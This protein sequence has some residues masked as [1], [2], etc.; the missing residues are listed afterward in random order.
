[1][2]CNLCAVLTLLVALAKPY[3]SPKLISDSSEPSR[4]G[5]ENILV[6]RQVFPVMRFGWS[7][8]TLR[9]LSLLPSRRGRE[10]IKVLFSGLSCDTLW[11]K[12]QQ[13]M[14]FDSAAGHFLSSVLRGVVASAL[15]VIVAGRQEALKLLYV[16]HKLYLYKNVFSSCKP[17]Y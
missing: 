14:A 13:F 4:K 9:P 15:W 7:F 12:F 17:S 10:S 16:F 2:H 6:L 3:F 5:R 11:A 8:I 1:M